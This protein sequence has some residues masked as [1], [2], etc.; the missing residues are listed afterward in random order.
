MVARAG[1]ASLTPLVNEI[2][3]S[4][5]SVLPVSPG[6]EP[7]LWLSSY[8]PLSPAAPPPI[9]IV[10]SHQ[11]QVPRFFL[12]GIISAAQHPL[13]A[14]LDWQGLISRSTP[15]I[16]LIEGDRPLLWQG[17]RTLIFLR[18]TGGRR[19]LVFNF[20]V[21]T[22]N[23]ARVPA[24]VI[25]IHRF[26]NLIRSEKVALEQLNVEWH[27]HLSLAHLSGAEAPP[28]ELRTSDQERTFPLSQAR[29][30]RAPDSHGFFEVSQGES[31]LLK[32]ASN[33]AEVREA[34]FSQA[35][36]VSEIGAL[37][38]RIKARQTRDDPM[39]PLWILLL[40]AATILAWAFL[41][42]PLNGPPRSADQQEVGTP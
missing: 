20:D 7:D 15:S 35:G 5:E 40:G 37:P 16:P 1:A 32:G 23:A 24:F 39:R 22:S 34:D 36:S 2:I 10:F 11:E 12:S 4:L 8:D 33:F 26:A 14:D 41:K 13:V 29:F 9:S 17:E 30:L 28:L 31:L 42:S 27:Q 18:E 3:H 38:D 25:L 21:A 19:Q 6:S